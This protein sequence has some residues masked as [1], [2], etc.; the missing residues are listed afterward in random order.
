[1]LCCCEAR[2]RREDL[3][4]QLSAGAL[5]ELYVKLCVDYPIVSIEDPFE[6]DDWES[7]TDL[8][9]KLTSASNGGRL[10]VQV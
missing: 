8:T 9:R 3:H 1:M 2:Q 4:D 7:W 6:Q 5:G 10:D